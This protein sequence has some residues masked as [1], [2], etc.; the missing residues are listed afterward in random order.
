MSALVQTTP[1]KGTPPNLGGEKVTLVAR[2]AESFSFFYQETL[3]HLALKRFFDPEKDV[4][5]FNGIDLLYLPGGYPEKHLEALTQNE[6]CRKVI[7]DYA[8]Q[9]GRIIAECGGMMYLCERIVTDEGD[10]PMCGVL[11]YSITARKQGVSR[12]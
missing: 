7:K 9:G 6:A 8:E 11:P 3:D 5:D 2:N 12:A 4:P 10:Y 1:P